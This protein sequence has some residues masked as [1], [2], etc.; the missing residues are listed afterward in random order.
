MDGSE[1]VV[2]T[3]P[4]PHSQLRTENA[5]LKLQKENAQLSAEIRQLSSPD[6]S[7]RPWWKSGTT[8]TTLT[9]ILAAV[10]PLTTA[11]Q[12][13]VQK[14]RE[15]ALEEAKQANAIAMQ[16]EKQT[17]D[18]R[19]GYLERTKD[20]QDRIRVL[21]FVLAT[22]ADP[23]LREWARNELPPVQDDI[24]KFEKAAAEIER[25]YGTGQ[26]EEILRSLNKLREDEMFNKRMAEVF[27]LAAKAGNLGREHR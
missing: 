3:E 4:D 2:S 5:A 18:I 22:S 26:K 14:S 1:S 16:R 20:P 25:I 19:T 23:R 17:E 10:V 21:H 8:I 15:L 9:A 27:D 6:V 24:A 11:V 13:W 12:G 7:A